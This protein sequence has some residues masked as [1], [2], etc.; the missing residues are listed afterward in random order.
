MIEI[1]PKGPERYA[2][3]GA[4]RNPDSSRLHHHHI[5]GN[6][7]NNAVEIYNGYADRIMW[8]STIRE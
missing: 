8:V 4:E 3:C 6:H 2:M 7:D 5:D 1:P